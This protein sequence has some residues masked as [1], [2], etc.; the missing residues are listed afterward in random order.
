MTVRCKLKVN[1]KETYQDGG[2]RIEMGPVYDGSEENKQFF[3]ATP[4]AKFDLQT[5]NE[6][7]AAQLE[8]GKEYYIDITE[9]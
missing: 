6:A 9:A 2:A 8:E 7:A 4:C 1:R 3:K 5:V